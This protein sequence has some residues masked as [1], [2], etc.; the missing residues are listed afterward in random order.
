MTQLTGIGKTG[1]GRR[2]STLPRHVTIGMWGGD[3]RPAAAR[4]TH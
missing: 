4:E 3:A 1:L 2:G